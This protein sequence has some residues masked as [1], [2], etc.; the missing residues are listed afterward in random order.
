MFFE[1]R[2]LLD[3]RFKYRPHKRL[4]QAGLGALDLCTLISQLVRA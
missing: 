1:Q 4:W 3:G 2:F